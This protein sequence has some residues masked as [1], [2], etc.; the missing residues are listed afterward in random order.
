M[1]GLLPARRGMT[2][3]ELVVALAIT[4]MMAAMGAATFSSIIDHRRIILSSTGELERASAL[5]DQIR[6]WMLSGTVQVVTG[7]ASRGLGRASSITANNVTFSANN[8]SASPIASGSGVSAITAA[9]AGGDE[10]TFVTTAPNPAN[11]PSV[12]MRLFIDVDESTPETGLTLEYQPS[13]STP[14]KRIQLEPTI[15]VLKV[16]FLDQ[17]TNQ[18]FESMQGAAVTPI[19]VRLSMQPYDG[20]R[21]PGILQLPMIFPIGSL[22][23]GR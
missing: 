6:T 19:A 16:E 18:W 3:M 21:L 7:G 22:L 9:V 8:S 4:G 5:R 11:A 15:G 10:I 2:L 20:G 13:T 12:R 14:L 1:K 23:V 17:R